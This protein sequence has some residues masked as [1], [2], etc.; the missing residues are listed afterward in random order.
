MAKLEKEHAAKVALLQ[1]A[2]EMREAKANLLSDLS[3]LHAA[4]QT[5]VDSLS[6]A[7]SAQKERVAQADELANPLNHPMVKKYFS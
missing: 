1:Q 2:R 4:K 5:K 3:K 7:V 6:L